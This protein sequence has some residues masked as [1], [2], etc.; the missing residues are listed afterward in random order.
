MSGM[1][2]EDQSERLL[3]DT[4]K[5]FRKGEVSAHPPIDAQQEEVFRIIFEGHTKQFM[6]DLYKARGGKS[7]ESVVAK[8]EADELLKKAG[9]KSKLQGPSFMNFVQEMTALELDEVRK[10]P[11][12]RFA[13]LVK[14]RKFDPFAKPFMRWIEKELAE[15]N[16]TTF[17]A[18]EQLETQFTF[19][20][21]TINEARHRSPARIEGVTDSNRDFFV[22]ALHCWCRA[23]LNFFAAKKHME[24]YLH[25]AETRFRS[26]AETL[27]ED[28]FELY[29]EYAKAANGLVSIPLPDCDPQYDVEEQD[30]LDGENGTIAEVR[31]HLDKAESLWHSGTTRRWY[32]VLDETEYM[33]FN[34]RRGRITL[35]IDISA[36]CL[37]SMN[38][39]THPS[40]HPFPERAYPFLEGAPLTQETAEHLWMRHMGDVYLE[41]ALTMARLG[42]FATAKE[43]L[44]RCNNLYRLA[45]RTAKERLPGSWK[46][47]LLTTAKYL[48]RSFDA[49]KVSAASHCAAI[50]KTTEALFALSPQPTHWIH[51]YDNLPIRVA[52]TH[53]NFIA[54]GQLIQDEVLKKTKRPISDNELLKCIELR[55]RGQRTPPELDFY[56]D[57]VKECGDRCF[58]QV[59]AKWRAKEVVGSDPY[60]MWT[61]M[62]FMFRVFPKSPEEVAQYWEMY[63][64][65]YFYIYTQAALGSR[66]RGYTHIN[67]AIRR[68][69][70][71][72]LDGSHE[73]KQTLLSELV[74]V[75]EKLALDRSITT[76]EA[77]LVSPAALPYCY[78]SQLIWKITKSGLN[79]QG[80][81]LL[82]INSG[83]KDYAV[84]KQRIEQSREGR[85][86]S[87][88]ANEDA[89]HSGSSSNL[90]A[91]PAAIN[92]R[93]IFAETEK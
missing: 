3:L 28:A 64:P 69:S 27:F 73:Q 2:S 10:N 57:A 16:Q 35:A 7:T 78:G 93:D 48:M 44:E 85:M 56:F 88:P 82:K 53:E 20:T 38:K 12:Q 47:P 9:A 31:G 25:F 13:V 51:I 30:F 89:A 54:Y 75:R 8:Q 40:V 26:R 50:E 29:G 81:A 67:D 49:S 74:K 66:T 55:A 1:V 70:Q 37:E 45:I 11:I 14:D 68:M 90:G 39:K 15:F 5:R 34:E 79:A 61:H 83:A 87:R 41:H 23:S 19:L 22:T 65:A 32:P 86:A 71:I 6:S 52:L 33:W 21:K 36:R 60:Y 17:S 80:N 58:R 46:A 42:Q 43:H 77:H 92:T 59:I 18:Q 63:E 4:I 72:L 62:Y 84:I 24:M 91:P 76:L